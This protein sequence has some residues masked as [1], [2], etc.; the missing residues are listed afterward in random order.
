[1]AASLDV[2]VFACTARG[3]VIRIAGPCCVKMTLF[4]NGASSV[5]TQEGPF[6]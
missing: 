2:H 1:M 5:K 6:L 3:M 4:R